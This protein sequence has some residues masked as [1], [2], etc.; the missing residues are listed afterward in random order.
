M[1]RRVSYRN[2]RQ[3]AAENHDEDREDVVITMFQ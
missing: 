2:M 1:Y 3:A